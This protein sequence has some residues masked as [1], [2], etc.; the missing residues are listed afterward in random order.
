MVLESLKA[1]IDDLV[2]LD[3]A[4]LADVDTLADLHRQLDRFEAVVTRAAGA[5]DTAGNWQD[6]KAATAASWIT[7][8]CHRP[9]ST[10]KAEIALARALRH[11][12]EAEAAWFA[13]DIG[14]AQ[15]RVLARVRRPATED[16]LAEHEEILVGYGAQLQ[17]RHFTR[18]VA[19]WAQVADPDGAD[20]TA[21]DQV[22]QR[23]F[24]LS[25]SFGGV[26]YADG[27]FDPIKGSILFKELSRIEK[28]FFEADWS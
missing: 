15:V 11:L 2:D 7:G 21:Q 14:A 25:Q 5:F 17:F 27:V 8:R 16:R 18:V 10:A 12:P 13:G 6:D 23:R 20:D 24:H 22:D 28:L 19:Y 26:W 4:A 3:P 9:A 1:A